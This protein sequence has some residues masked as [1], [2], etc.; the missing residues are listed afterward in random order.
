MTASLYYRFLR[1]NGVHLEK[2]CGDFRLMSRR[3]VDALNQLPER[4]R[5][6]RAMVGWIGYQ[7]DRIYFDRP[8][9]KAGVTK[10]P[11][12]KM[13]ALASDGIVSFSN[14]PLRIAY[15]LAV[16]LSCIVFGYAAYTGVKVCFFGGTVVPGWTSLFLSNAIFSA[17]NLLCLGI[18]G[19]YIGRIYSEEKHRPLFLIKDDTNGEK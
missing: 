4:N 8:A 1:L 6:L 2:D 7:T 13:L 12:R 5:L 19:E 3:A 18:M 10:Y 11:L 15:L 16:I 17:S 14:M 9:R